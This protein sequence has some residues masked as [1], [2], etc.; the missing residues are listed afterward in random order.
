MFD[1]ISRL[2]PIGPLAQSIPVDVTIALPVQVRTELLHDLY[3]PASPRFRQ[4]LRPEQYIQQFGPAS[5]SYQNLVVLAQANHLTVVSTVPPQFIYVVAP[6]A[7]VN[8]VFAMTL[9]QYRHPTEDRLFSA[10]DVDAVVA[11]EIPGLQ[12]TGLDTLH[13][14]RRAPAGSQERGVLAPSSR[15]VGPA[16]T[17]GI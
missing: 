2:Q 5:A 10:P 6:A 13:M 4:F 1:V 8:Q 14:P 16:R 12:I 15:P 9:Q 3:D 7:V 11:L 17:D